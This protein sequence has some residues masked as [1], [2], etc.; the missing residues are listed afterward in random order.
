MIYFGRNYT[1][2]SERWIAFFLNLVSGLIIGHMTL[3][4]SYKASTK[5]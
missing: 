2:G 5:R 1:P 4:Q 3:K